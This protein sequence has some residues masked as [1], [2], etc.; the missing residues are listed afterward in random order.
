M[1]EELVAAGAYDIMTDNP[2]LGS[3]DFLSRLPRILR[4]RVATTN[5]TRWYQM[6]RAVME[7]VFWE[8]GVEERG[9]GIRSDKNSILPEEIARVYIAL[10]DFLVAC[11]ECLQFDFP[12]N[13]MLASLR[14]LL[15]RAR[16]P[17][18]RA[19]LV[20]LI[21]IFQS[22][23]PLSL[24]GLEIRSTLSGDAVRRF[25]DLLED[26]LYENLSTAGWKIG[27][28]AR[29]D[30]AKIMFERLARRIAHSAAFKPI[31]NLA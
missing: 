21:G 28:P 10:P 26:E 9:G 12:L 25:E 16:E 2:F 20:T 14:S 3:Y 18:A 23:R 17:R 7:P 5:S 4:K 27:L 19:N 29:L 22:Y 1:I 30:R 13:E 8:F 24:E 15:D 31:A 6:A 11:H